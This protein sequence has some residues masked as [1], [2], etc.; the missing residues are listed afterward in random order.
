M[1]GDAL[2][3]QVPRDASLAMLPL[4]IRP[5][6]G[7]AFVVDWQGTLAVLRS[8]SPIGPETPGASIVDDVRWLHAFLSQ[9]TALGFP[10]PQ[11]LLA[12]AD[13]SWTVASGVICELVSFVPGSAVG[14]SPRPPMEEIGALLARYHATAEQIRMP[15]QRPTA[16]PLAEVPGILPAGAGAGSAGV[17]GCLP[18]Q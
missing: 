2:P 9:L 12:I 1:D 17:I 8:A 13:D 11:P 3:H 5:R 4:Q 16:L 15:V 14:W 18:G 10:A 7:T 6:Q